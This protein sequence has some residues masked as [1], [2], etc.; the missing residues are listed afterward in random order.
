M[1]LFSSSNMSIFHHLTCRI[2]HLTTTLQDSSRPFDA[3]DD[4]AKVIAATGVSITLLAS[5][6]HASRTVDQTA[7]IKRE[8]A[9]KLTLKKSATV[10]K[11]TPH[12]SF[13][14]RG[15]K[16]CGAWK[17]RGRLA[18]SFSILT[19]LASGNP[20]TLFV[21]GLQNPWSCGEPR[22]VSHPH[23]SLHSAHC[24][25]VSRTSELVAVAMA[26]RMQG[27]V[28]DPD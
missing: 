1:F 13:I 20:I 23:I 3:T 19:L 28:S 25:L 9:I 5:R 26:C 14:P 7:W 8:T 15:V 22:R 16:R 11:I 17:P 6:P 21:A 2:S 24:R 18:F 27:G 4:G 12:H 10:S